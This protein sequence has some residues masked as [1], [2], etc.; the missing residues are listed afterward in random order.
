MRDAKPVE[1]PVIPSKTTSGRRQAPG[2]IDPSLPAAEDQTP[3]HGPPAAAGAVIPSYPPDPSEPPPSGEVA[4]ENEPSQTGGTGPKADARKGAGRAATRKR[5][6]AEGAGQQPPEDNAASGALDKRLAF[7]PMTDLGNAERF[8]ERNRDKFIWCSAVGWFWW[9]GKRWCRDGVDERVQIA[10]HLTV[11]SI[12]DEADAIAGTT[13]D[14]L[15]GEKG[16]KDDKQPIMLSDLL[17]AFG[18]ASE[19]N[20]KLNQ[21]AEQAQAYLSVLPIHL[22]ADPFAI[23]VANGTLRVK[24]GQSDSDPI[25]FTKHDPKD[26]I[27]KIAPIEYQPDAVSPLYDAFLA[28][29][30]PAAE[31][32]RFLHQWTGLSLTGDISEQRLCVF[33]GTGKNGKSVFIETA[34]LIAG[35]YSDTVP[36]ET[37]LSEGRGRN[38]GQATPDL[39]ILPGV[40]LLRTSEPQRGASFD[41]GLLKL[42]TGG[43][44]I[45]AR[46]LNR[47]YFRFYPKFKL[48]ISGNQRPRVGGTDEGIWRRMTL[49]PWNVTIP[50]DKRDPQL[51]EKLKAEASGIL[52]RYLDGLRDWLEN[53]LKLPDA[54]TEA[55][56]EYRRDHDTLG[57]FLEDCTE[58]KPGSIVGV[59]EALNLFNAWAIGNGFGEWKAKGFSNAMT[60]RGFVKF[61]SDTMYFRDLVLTKARSD[62]VDADGRPVRPSSS[63]RL[64]EDAGGWED[65]G[66]G[67]LEF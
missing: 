41:E 59:T 2:P 52:N 57:R 31:M 17:R 53:R 6:K 13:F 49:V 28:D 67:G 21:L 7:F 35:D 33:W 39:A 32:R 29:V 24:K 47:D 25:A 10:A 8:R 27:T 5:A 16:P 38:A 50:E 66:D 46:H 20:S 63:A 12:Q 56:A 26:L 30:Q 61:K 18:R 48:T 34:A 45:I 42:V 4:S 3:L 58:R 65:R 22:D 15:C 62:F 14:Q 55:T 60:E 51:V 54:V 1:R 23:N 40:R 36:I 11:R 19:T 9:D 37:F 64:R 44:P 43:E